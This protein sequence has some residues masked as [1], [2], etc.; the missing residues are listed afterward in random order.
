MVNETQVVMPNTDQSVILFVDL[1]GVRAKWLKGGRAAAEKAFDDFRSLIARAVKQ[2][3]TTALVEGLVESDAMALKFTNISSALD[4]A[5]RMYLMAFERK[6][7]VLWL[8]G[9]VVPTSPEGYL[10]K[11]T[12]FSGTMSNVQLMLY[13][14]SLLDGI[15]IEKAGFKGMRLVVPKSLMTAEARAA[16]KMPIGSLNLMAVSKLRDS[17]YPKRLADEFH[18]FLWMANPDEAIF[19]ELQKVMAIRLRMAASDPEE[20]AQA[21][22][23]QVVFHECAAILN[24]LRGKARYKERLAHNEVAP[25]ES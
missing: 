2:A 22:A 10:R 5:R 23:T 19:S 9:C 17:T 3:K 7:G 18:D 20:F 8:R 21:A 13:S 24:S 15:S 1:L 12:A 14:A 4:V 16:T 25:T 6:N 11:P